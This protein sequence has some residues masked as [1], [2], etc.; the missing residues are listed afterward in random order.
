VN[1]N[2]VLAIFVVVLV[3]FSGLIFYQFNAANKG[4]SGTPQPSGTTLSAK[5]VT[6][7]N[8]TFKI[9]LARTPEEQQKGLSN[10]ASLPEDHGMLFLFDKPAPYGFW[11]KEMRFPLDIIF[12]KNKTVVTVDEN[13]PAPVSGTEYPPVYY[14]EQ[15]VDMVLEIN[16]SLA[17]EYGIESGDTIKINKT[18]DHPGYRTL[19][20]AR[21]RRV[22][23]M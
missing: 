21:P 11:M 19:D 3:P 20:V 5:S 16:A 9:E 13:L 8:R 4:K 6:I 15:P 22:C 14:P 10:R 23:V 2:R 7:N 1:L 12:I 17:Q 18:Y